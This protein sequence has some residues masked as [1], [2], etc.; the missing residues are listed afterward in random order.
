[1]KLANYLTKHNGILHVILNEIELAF[2]LQKANPNSKPRFHLT[3]VD[4]F[5][6][7]LAWDSR[8]DGS[9]LLEEKNRIR[10]TS[11]NIRYRILSTVIEVKYYCSESYFPYLEFHIP[12]EIIAKTL[13][14][15]KHKESANNHSVMFA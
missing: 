9:F 13:I 15:R 8:W 14:Y 2:L 1:M 5:L 10:F 4:Q 6:Y 11:S 12:S 3:K 7:R